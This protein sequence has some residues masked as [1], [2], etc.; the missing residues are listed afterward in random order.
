MFVWNS[1]ELIDHKL[2]LCVPLVEYFDCFL[3]CSSKQRFKLS[4]YTKIPEVKLLYSL[5]TFLFLDI[6]LVDYFPK[7]WSVHLPISKLYTQMP[8]NY[9]SLTAVKP[10]W[11]HDHLFSVCNLFFKI[12]LHCS[13]EKWKCKRCN[14]R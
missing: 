3:F 7:T 14:F 11:I 1:V 5:N 4:P 9:V 12:L 2:C 6:I 8:F 10:V 13:F